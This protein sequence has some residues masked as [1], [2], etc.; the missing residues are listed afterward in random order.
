[1][2]ICGALL[3]LTLL[4]VDGGLDARR[5]ETLALGAKHIQPPVDLVLPRSCLGGRTTESC[6]SLSVLGRETPRGSLREVERAGKA[7]DRAPGLVEAPLERDDAIGAPATPVRGSDGRRKGRLVAVDSGGTGTNPGRIEIGG[8][9]AGAGVRGDGREGLRAPLGRLRRVALSPRRCTMGGRLALLRAGKTPAGL[10]KRLDIGKAI[11]IGRQRSE[12]PFGPG[13][14]PLGIGL[15]VDDRGELGIELGEPARAPGRAGVCAD[16]L[17]RLLGEPPLC[18]A[19]AEMAVAADR[20]DMRRQLVLALHEPD[21]AEDPLDDTCRNRASL[22]RCEHPGEARTLRLPRRRVEKDVQRISGQ[23]RSVGHHPGV[24]QSR[25][26][27]R[28]F[29]PGLRDRVE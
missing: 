7:A 29:D 1:M 14:R 5:L 27:E 28:G 2:T 24:E 18:R 25:A 15:T 13:D 21:R 17:G 19:E 12:T 10:A 8:Q 26:F 23:H 3:A 11:R 16:I 6:L 4:R 22:A 9:A 20:A